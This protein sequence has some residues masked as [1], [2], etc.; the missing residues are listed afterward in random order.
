MTAFDIEQPGVLPDYLRQTRR[1]GAA[2]EV[3]CRVLTGGVSNRT[4]LVQRPSG[5]AWVVKQALAKLRTAAEW[6]SDPARIHREALGLRWLEKIAPV[7][8][9]VFEDEQNHLLAMQAIPEPHA[10]W[11]TLLLAGQIQL[12]HFRQFGRM[13]GAKWDVKNFG[14]SGTTLLKNGDNPY[15][16]QNAFH[17]AKELNPDVVVIALGTN[18]TKPQNWKHFKE[19]FEADYKDMVLQFADL[20]AKLPVLAE[21]RVTSVVVP[22]TVSRT[23]KS[24]ALLASP[25]ARSLARL[26]KSR[27]RPSGVILGAMDSRLP[28]L[29]PL[30]LTLIS[31]VVPATKSRR[32]TS[33]ALLVSFETKSLAAL[34]KT[35]NWPLELIV[36]AC[37]AALP[38]PAPDS[39]TLT[40]IVL[41]SR[42]SRTNTSNEPLLSLVTRLP[43]ALTKTTNRP[44]ALTPGLWQSAAAPADCANGKATGATNELANDEVTTARTAPRDKEKCAHI[45]MLQGRTDSLLSSISAGRPE[46]RRR[47]RSGRRRPLRSTR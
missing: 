35:T 2:E 39:L 34:S 3:V 15:Q 18:D 33:E 16:R 14:V 22:A 36:G 25:T 45:F 11:K 42:R 47:R 13:L 26:A 23:N 8:G 12:D 28:G 9:F 6:F 19:H 29:T 1:I 4:V 24:T 7:P 32:K 21:L 43:A 17:R 41:P 40:S 5:E 38:L 27:Y 31:V 30:V 20:P 44:S 10:N 37:E 46:S